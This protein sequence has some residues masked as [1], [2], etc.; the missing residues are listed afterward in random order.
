M[1]WKK[2]R[3]GRNWKI[4]KNKIKGGRKKAEDTIYF[5][6]NG[7]KVAL[8][9][10]AVTMATEDGGAALWREAAM[11]FSALDKKWSEDAQQN[12]WLVWGAQ[13]LCLLFICV[14]L[15]QTQQV[16]HTSCS[17]C[18]VTPWTVKPR[19]VSCLWE[20]RVFRRAQRSWLLRSDV[21]LINSEP[22]EGKVL[23]LQQEQK[24]NK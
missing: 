18:S 15:S 21:Y 9:M 10:L 20:T 1:T 14:C 12:L 23:K 22:N 4:R 16:T 7:I 3:Q 13:Q 5:T 19:H 11:W 6:K 8:V 2:K 17:V 24:I